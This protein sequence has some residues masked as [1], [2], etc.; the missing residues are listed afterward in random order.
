MFSFIIHGLGYYFQQDRKGGKS[1][2]FRELHAE[3]E[4]EA[5]CRT[6]IS[7]RH[8]SNKMAKIRDYYDFVSTNLWACTLCDK[9]LKSTTTSNLITHFRQKHEEEYADFLKISWR[10]KK[11]E[12]N[13]ER[14]K[15][16]R[17]FV[18]IP[19]VRDNLKLNSD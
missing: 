4:S 16:K 5:D 2:E 9:Q 11:D 8:L 3:R 1:I 12:D 14:F 10:A 17:K 19:L 7:W 13:L 6:V 18:P 15:K